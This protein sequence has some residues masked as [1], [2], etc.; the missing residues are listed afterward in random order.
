MRHYYR[1]RYKEAQRHLEGRGMVWPKRRADL[2]DTIDWL[3]LRLTTGIG[4]KKLT[5]EVNRREAAEKR[6]GEPKKEYT[7]SAVAK[8]VQGLMQ[9]LRIE[10]SPE[11][12]EATKRFRESAFQDKEKSQS[13]MR[14]FTKKWAQKLVCSTS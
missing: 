11:S 3:F 1:E 8:R 6:Q 4:W 14:K 2:D 7:W 5:N 10:P 13:Y 9:I 12:L